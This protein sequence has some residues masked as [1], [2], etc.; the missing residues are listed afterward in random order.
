MGISGIDSSAVV[1]G[2]IY[3]GSRTTK[4]SS[5]KAQKFEETKE[6]M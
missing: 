3:P 6:I 1:S 2:G 5:E 4:G